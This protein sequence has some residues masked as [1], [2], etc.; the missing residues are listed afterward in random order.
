MDFL[1]RKILE[2]IQTNNEISRD[3]VTKTEDHNPLNKGVNVLEKVSGIV[4]YCYK[5]KLYFWFKIELKQNYNLDNMFTEDI[6]KLAD[7]KKLSGANFNLKDIKENATE[8][9]NTYIKKYEKLN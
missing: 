2:I 9:V 6:F 4:D 3:L 8:L 1:E 5:I 7:P